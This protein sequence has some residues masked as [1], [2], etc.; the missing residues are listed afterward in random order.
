MISMTIRW[1]IGWLLSL[2]LRF[3]AIYGWPGVVVSIASAVLCFKVVRRSHRPILSFV[4][5]ASLIGAIWCYWPRKPVRPSAPA[6]H[7]RNHASRPLGK[8]PIG[9]R[10]EVPVRTGHRG[11]VPNR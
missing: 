1:A 11:S 8:K 7:S 6:S 10:I 5:M 4:V 9:K 3:V 2:P